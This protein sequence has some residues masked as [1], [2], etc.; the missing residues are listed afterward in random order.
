MKVPPKT[1]L[2]NFGLFLCN[3]PIDN[4]AR[5]HFS[6]RISRETLGSAVIGDCGMKRRELDFS[7]VPAGD[8]P[9]RRSLEQQVEELDI[10]DRV[11][12]RGYVDDS[13]GPMVAGDFLV[14]ISDATVAPTR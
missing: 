8:G 2:V 11:T 13:P 3:A 10:S 12:F 5:S 4:Q 6:R 1:A 9:L 7:M 14:H